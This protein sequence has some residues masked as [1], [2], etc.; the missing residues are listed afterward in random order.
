MKSQVHETS[1]PPTY[2]DPVAQWLARLAW[3]MDRAITVPGSRVSVGLDAVLGLLPLGGDVLTGC[4]Q[5]ALVL[6][7]LGHYRVPR[8]VAV[9]MLSNVLLDVAVGA[10]PV[11]GDVFDVAFK[12]NTRNMQLLEPYLPGGA[13]KD[14]SS[15]VIDVTPTRWRWYYVAPI[16]IAVIAVMVLALVGFVAVVRWLFRG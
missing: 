7:A 1:P 15:I 2:T 11:L 16:L 9:R 10:V 3:L 4:V 13:R 6:I 8:H 12:A 5:T 14:P